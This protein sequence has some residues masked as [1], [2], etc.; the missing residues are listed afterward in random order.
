MKMLQTLQGFLSPLSKTP[1]ADTNSE[2]CYKVF[3]TMVSPELTSPSHQRPLQ[4]PL[5]Y[6]VTYSQKTLHCH[7]S[8][9]A[10]GLIH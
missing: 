7:Q 6:L 3:N 1:V 5:S 10:Y 8:E 9:I 2:N 4:Y